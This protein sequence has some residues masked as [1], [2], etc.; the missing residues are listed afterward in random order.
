VVDAGGFSPAH[1]WVRT[2]LI[3]SFFVLAST[4]EELAR[5]LRDWETSIGIA[6]V[7]IVWISRGDSITC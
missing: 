6:K 7:S 2:T 3:L 5:Y 1:G 4:A